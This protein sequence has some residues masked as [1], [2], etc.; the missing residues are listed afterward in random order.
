MTKFLKFIGVLVATGFVVLLCMFFGNPVSKL[1]VTQNAKEYLEE[2]YQGTDFEIET[3][4]YDFKT[5]NYYVN[6]VSPSSLDSSFTLYAGLNGK[7]GYDTYENAVVEKWNTATR[8]NNQYWD[9]KKAVK[10]SASA[11]LT[12]TDLML[13]SAD[14][15]ISSALE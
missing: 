2:N 13:K 14:S 10:L 4:N 6:I 15:A 3:V 7:I 9:A 1:L 5:S 8:I 12:N 11:M